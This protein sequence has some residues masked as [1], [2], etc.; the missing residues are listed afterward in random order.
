MCGDVFPYTWDLISCICGTEIRTLARS[1]S[2]ITTN[3]KNMNMKTMTTSLIATMVILTAFAAI[4]MPASANGVKVQVGMAL[5]SS[6]SI[7]S[8][9]WGVITE[10]VASAVENPDCVPH[11]GSVELTLVRFASGASVVVGPV[12][13]TAANANT[14]AS[15][16]RNIAYTGGGTNIAAGIRVTADAMNGSGNFDPSIKQVINIATDGSSNQTAAVNARNYAITLLGMTE[17][18]DEID[19]E[20]ID[21]TDANRDWLKDNI[22]F[23]QPG[24]IAPPYTGPGWVRVVANAQEFA[25]SMCKKFEAVIDDEPCCPPVPVGPDTAVGGPAVPVLTPFGAVTLIGLLAVA[26]VIGIRRRT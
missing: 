7:G 14:V 9:D 23:P 20:G 18:Q 25:E 5:D 19:A 4:T 24:Y 3:E 26:G 17:A 6:G 8:T 1:N 11:D 22:V 16:I 2:R 15:D 10:G 12:V 13:I 21:I